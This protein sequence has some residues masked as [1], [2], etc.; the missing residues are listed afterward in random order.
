MT[1]FLS[2]LALAPLVSAAVWQPAAGS[3][4]AIQ[5]SVPV[6]V[7]TLSSNP[8]SIIVLDL[9]DNPT[10]TIT[11]IHNAGKKAICYFS[12]GTY[13][14][15]RSDASSF[16][17]E[18]YGNE[19]E[20]WPGEFWLKTTRTSVRNI[21]KARLDLA[22]TKGCDGVDPDNMDAYSPNNNSGTGLTQ[23]QGADYVKFLATEA[24]ARDLAIGL[25]N[26]LDIIPTVVG[27]VQYAV[28]EECQDYNECDV[29]EPFVSAGKP[30]FAIE[31]RTNPT[32]LS[33]SQKDAICNAPDTTGFSILIKK[34]DLD[35]V[36]YACP[37]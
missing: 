24:H 6:D 17:P 1:R 15:W 11:A 22:E 30:V 23:A 5:L 7:S 18:D 31:Y 16:V 12:A 13:E 2:L 35:T 14:I 32:G 9:F 26:A 20:E 4:W 19:M 34:Y 21:M 28:N 37:V 27:D 10:S 25:K 29:Y 8:A 36:V 33:A 3:T